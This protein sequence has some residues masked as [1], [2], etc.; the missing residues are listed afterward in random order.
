MRALSHSEAIGDISAMKAA[1]EY[2]LR[3]QR[4]DGSWYY[5]APGRTKLPSPEL[6][7]ALMLSALLYANPESSKSARQK[8]MAYLLDHQRPDGSWEGGFFPIE[9]KRQP[10]KEYVFATSRAMIVLHQWSKEMMKNK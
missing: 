1:T 2:I 3:A 9:N 5:A 4:E 10:K 8:G 6:Q 7:T